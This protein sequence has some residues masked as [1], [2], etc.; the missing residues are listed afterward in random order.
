MSFLCSDINLHSNPVTTRALLSSKTICNFYSMQQTAPTRHTELT[1]YIAAL[2]QTGPVTT[3]P[4]PHIVH[5]IHAGWI[6]R[7]S[8]QSPTIPMEIHYM[9]ALCQFLTCQ[10][11][12]T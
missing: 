7:L 10:F 6:Q 1:Q 3:V 8:L 9:T 4:L 11:L 5:D 2:Q 12:C